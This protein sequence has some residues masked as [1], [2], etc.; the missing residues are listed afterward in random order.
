MLEFPA[1]QEVV[2]EVVAEARH[3]A[4]LTVLEARFGPVP[5]DLAADLRGIADEQRL[6][7]LTK[8]AALSPNLDVF[9][10]KLKG[11]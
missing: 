1:V 8:Q 10:S 11:Q 4:I 3:K 7:D 2:A 5:E 9:R 6:T